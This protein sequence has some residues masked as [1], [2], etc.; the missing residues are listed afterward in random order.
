MQSVSLQTS[1]QQAKQ[2][3]KG[4][5]K[6]EQRTN[7]RR[8]EESVTPAYL[9][10]G[11]DK[12]VKAVRSWLVTVFRV[13]RSREQALQLLYPARYRKVALAYSSRI[14]AIVPGK[15]LA[16]NHN[17]NQPVDT[18]TSTSTST[19]T[20]Q[21]Q[22]LFH[23][24]RSIATRASATNPHGQEKKKSPLFRETNNGQRTTYSARWHVQ[25]G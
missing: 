17:H 4:K 22:T 25:G 20:P 23:P 8:R 19:T 12:W 10:T 11:Q 24:L 1:K 21:T 18:S 13:R 14:L 16:E 3:E 6:Y 7:E 5:V 9:G 2:A 15:A